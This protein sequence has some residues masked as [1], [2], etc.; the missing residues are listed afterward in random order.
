MEDA[1]EMLRSWRAMHPDAIQLDGD[2]GNNPNHWLHITVNA[3]DDDTFT[4]RHGQTFQ[5]KDYN[6]IVN[7]HGDTRAQAVDRFIELID[8][9]EDFH[10]VIRPS[11]TY[12]TTTKPKK[13]KVRPKFALQGYRDE[14]EGF[15]LYHDDWRSS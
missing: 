5:G 11:A 14:V 2:V 4:S 10:D 15:F 8:A 12:E 9:A 3:Y 7:F 1:V 13:G 6:G